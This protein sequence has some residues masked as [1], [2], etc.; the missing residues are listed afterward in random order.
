[1]GFDC[2]KFCKKIQKKAT[3]VFAGGKTQYIVGRVVGNYNCNGDCNNNTVTGMTT[4]AT[5]NIGKIEA[6]KTVNQ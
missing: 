1:M 2:R 3:G 4:S 5:E 6:G